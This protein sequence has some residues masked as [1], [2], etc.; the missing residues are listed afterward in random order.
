VSVFIGVKTNSKMFIVLK[1]E[2]IFD[3]NHNKTV[4]HS[5]YQSAQ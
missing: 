5:R 1:A 3:S 2:V 4:P